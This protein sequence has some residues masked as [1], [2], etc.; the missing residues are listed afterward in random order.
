MKQPHEMRPGNRHARAG[1][2]HTRGQ[3]LAA[4]MALVAVCRRC[5]HRAVLYPANLVD[6]FGTDCPSIEVRAHLRCSACRYRSANLHESA[7]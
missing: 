6:R 7:R 1:Q 4:K 5:K 3:L 2:G